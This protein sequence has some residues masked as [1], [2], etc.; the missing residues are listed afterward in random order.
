MIIGKKMIYSVRKGD[1]LR[2]IGAKFGVNW[3]LVARQNK[4]DAKKSLKPGQKL[5]INTRRIVPKTLQ[6]GIVINIPDR[7]L[8]FFKNRKLEKV[9]PVALGMTNLHDQV[10]WQTPTGT[11]RILSKIK[12]PA[13]HVPPSIQKE[14]E[15]DRKTV[16]TLVPPGDDN[17]LGKYALKTSLPGILIHS[18]IVPESIYTFSSHGCIRVLASNME[19][20]FNEVT[21]NTRGEIIYQPVKL[22]LSDNGLIYLEVHHDVYDRHENLKVLANRLIK[23][24]NLELLVDWDKVHASLQRKAGVPEDITGSATPKHVLTRTTHTPPHKTVIQTASPAMTVL[25]VSN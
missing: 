7:T 8:Y 20:I 10:L 14:M 18:T 5:T 13:W 21:I 2:L 25:P 4:L 19:A 9:L 23:K 12:D 15:Q 11:F 16:K 1:S 24:N 6:D 3:R 22:A 17:P